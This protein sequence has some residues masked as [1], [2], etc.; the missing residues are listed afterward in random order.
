MTI[1][2]SIALTDRISRPL[3]A[4]TR[5]LNT[6][7]SSFE[8]MNR[9]SANPINT[10][11]LAAARNE[12]AQVGAQ[13]RTMEEEINRASGS[14]ERL[15]GNIRRAETETNHGARGQRNFNNEI[16]RG[17]RAA[18]RLVSGLKR[19][20]GVYMSIRTAGQMI[21]LSDQITQ[22][23]TRLAMTVD[24]GGSVDELNAKIF[25][26]A[27][28]ARASYLGTADVVSKLGQRAGAAFQNNDETIQFAEN[29]NKLFVVA[30]ASQQEMYSASL[31]LTQA[32]GS[33]VL[34]GEELNAVFEAAPNVIQTI[35]DYLDV[36]I[37]KIRGMASDGLITADI[38][39]NAMLS[40]T[41]DINQKFDSMP[42]TF[43][44]VWQ[45][46]KNNAL[47]AFVP[48]SKQLNALANSQEMQALSQNAIL[49]VNV[50]STAVVQLFQLLGNAGSFVYDNWSVL[51]PVILGVAGV[52]GVYTAATKG[53]A[54][55][56]ALFTG[57]Q[58]GFAA[59]QTIV[60]VGYGVLTG[61]TVA[62]SDATLL[63]NSS[64]LACPLT[65]LLMIMI[66]V[67]AVIYGVVAA[68]N[69][70]KGT[71]ISA[72]GIIS[73]AFYGLWAFI[74]NIFIQWQ[75]LF[76]DV[77]NFIMNC[78]NDPVSAVQ[79]LFYDM[80]ITIIGYIETMA[81]VIEDVINKIPG[82][83]VDI[84]G[85]LD[86]F[87]NILISKANEAKDKAQ[88]VEYVEKWE[89]KDISKQAAKGY[90][91]G[92]TFQAEAKDWLKDT[93]G[94]GLKNIGYVPDISAAVVNDGIGDDVKSIADNTAKVADSNLLRMSAS[95]FDF[96]KAIA[97]RK[98]FDKK[99][100]I[101]VSMTNNNSINSELDIDGIIGTLADGLEEKMAV[102]A[103]GVY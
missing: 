8:E 3:M 62:A 100:E 99:V 28:R 68:F 35:A 29:L 92:D 87:K 13:L 32:L 10:Q 78:F 12:L 27:Q 38:V 51:S 43:A 88:W 45:S 72:T 1:S 67:V 82:V 53:A 64:L 42:M 93:F 96:I 75:N 22:T 61:S 5:A 70:W 81:K 9:A 34:R 25:A 40:A 49:A 71:T 41:E 60:S 6:T 20:A 97:E 44:Q 23:D 74:Q 77:A 91:A 90:Q 48:I 69:K 4:I 52:I 80:T 63:F 18:N 30:G 31:Q 103:E 11:A 89:Y 79:I 83:E 57:I 59:V 7:I 2:A 65:W 50:F 17:E 47:Q 66:A 46:F 94:T 84:T 26:S 76:A 21:K 15:N 85:G 39:K 86:N 14:Q 24:D 73:G 56:T 36:P 16:N 95:D 37:G 19:I 33:G 98:Y 55:A 58:R 101:Q 54:L 102:M